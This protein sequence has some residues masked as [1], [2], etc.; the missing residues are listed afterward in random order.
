VKLLDGAGIY[1]NYEGVVVT[2]SGATDNPSKTSELS[3][4]AQ[5]LTN[6]ARVGI[7]TKPVSISVLFLISY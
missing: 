1:G 3:I 4:R 7:E 5:Q 2:G 6:E